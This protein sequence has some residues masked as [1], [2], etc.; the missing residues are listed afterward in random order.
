MPLNEA[1]GEIGGNDVNMTE[2]TPLSPENSLPRD[3]LEFALSETY[4]TSLAFELNRLSHF[5]AEFQTIL[6]R[7]TLL[8]PEQTIKRRPSLYHKCRPSLYH[9]TP[10]RRNLQ[11]L[12]SLRIGCWN[13]CSLRRQFDEVIQFVTDHDIDIFLI[14]ETFLQLGQTP[15]IPNFTLYKNDKISINSRRT[16]GGTCIYVKKALVHYQIP[17]PELEST[18]ATI[19]NLNIGNK[20][21]NYAYF[22]LL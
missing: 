12:H 1:N 10:N 7:Q 17:T 11:N 22:I 18:E 16:S 15:N 8:P 14:Q 20:K 5:H 19:I 4:Q 2:S 21:S 9:N 6:P 3:Y 13:A